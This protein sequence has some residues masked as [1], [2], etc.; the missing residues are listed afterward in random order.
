MLRRGLDTGIEGSY[1]LLGHF[2]FPRSENQQ[3]LHPK[4]ALQPSDVLLIERIAHRDTEAFA[5]LYDRHHAILLGLLIRILHNRTEAEDVLQEVFLAVWQRAAD[6]TETRGTVFTWL[7]TMT[8]SRAIDRL[9]S[10]NARERLSTQAAQEAQF[11]ITD[12]KDTAAHAE[13]CEIVQRALD[14]VTE[15]QRNALLLAYFEGL[16]QTE[17]ARRLNEPLGTIKSRMRAA[18]LK[19]HEL[20][21][22]HRGGDG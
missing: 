15:Q 20:L 11:H 18:L 16:S 12:A 19:L 7:V 14:G 10:H 5:S 3:G 1:S 21:N 8:R 13:R 17:I 4:S 2:N 6:Y 9:R 22:E